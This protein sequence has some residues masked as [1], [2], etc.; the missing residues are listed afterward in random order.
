MRVPRTV[1]STLAAR[2]STPMNRPLSAALWS[3][4]TRVL[5]VAVNTFACSAVK[6]NTL[7]FAALNLNTSACSSANVN[8]S[9]C[10]AVKVNTSACSA[11]NVHTSACSAINDRQCK[12]RR[13]RVAGR[14]G[15]G[16]SAVFGELLAIMWDIWSS[17]AR[18]IFRSLRMETL[19][20]HRTSCRISFVATQIAVLKL[21]QQRTITVSR[22]NRF[23]SAM[24][25]RLRRRSVNKSLETHVRVNWRL[26]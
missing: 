23:E 16:P 3:F 17:T 11:V 25:N 8:T 5:R 19:S 12:P 7:A 13:R 14:R 2:I 15:E 10:S 1:C 4:V 18:R 9:A 6:I 22:K 21:S 24:R 20:E 26:T